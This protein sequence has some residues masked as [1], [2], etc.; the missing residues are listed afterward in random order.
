MNFF[1]FFGFGK[2]VERYGLKKFLPYFGLLLA[3][4][5]GIALFH[6]TLSLMWR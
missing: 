2:V 1:D 5:L 6:I 4:V 3:V